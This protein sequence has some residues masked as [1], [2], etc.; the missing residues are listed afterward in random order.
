[1][2]YDL[3]D[4]KLFI[5][6]GET[7]NLTR[8]AE[9]IFLSLPAASARVKNLEDSLKVRLLNRQATGVTMTPAGEVLYKYAKSVFQQLEQMHNEMQRLRYAVVAESTRGGAN[10]VSV[11]I[12][13]R[14]PFILI[15]YRHR[16][17]LRRLPRKWTPLAMSD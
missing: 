13:Q 6:I 4:L 8:A 1:M 11:F 15:I 10:G 2:R 9:K 5:Y 16:I 17:A 3:T 14:Q 12:D 7:S